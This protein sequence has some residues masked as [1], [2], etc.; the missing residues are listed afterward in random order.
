VERE[1]R[2]RPK[3]VLPGR[4]ST[5]L[6]PS[7]AT[8]PLTLDEGKSEDTLA[9]SGG[10]GSADVLI[11]FGRGGALSP[12][13]SRRLHSP[14]S[15]E[16]FMPAWRRRRA[17]PSVS[18]GQRD[19][20]LAQPRKRRGSASGCGRQHPPAI[21][22]ATVIDRHAAPQAPKRNRH[23]RP[24]RMSALS[25]RQSPAGGWPGRVQRRR[26]GR[27]DRAASAPQRTIV[28]AQSQRCGSAE[29]GTAPVAAAATD[30]PA[31]PQGQAW[32]AERVRVR[33][34]DLR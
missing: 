31:D 29:P 26:S 22:K 23:E 18:G 20:V 7:T 28:I 9:R 17:R 25:E 8:C 15:G 21:R 34:A 10:S 19:R 2:R 13:A 24:E 16:V 1:R 5:A 3:S 11:R 32:Q 14:G 27:P 6:G 4:I 30:P 33:G 12:R